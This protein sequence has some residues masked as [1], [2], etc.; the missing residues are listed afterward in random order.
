MRFGI[1]LR[2]D[3]DGWMEIYNWWVVVVVGN[4]ELTYYGNPV[5]DRFGKEGSDSYDIDEFSEENEENGNRCTMHTSSDTSQEHENVVP[6]ICIG[7]ELKERNFGGSFFL[8]RPF[9]LLFIVLVSRLSIIVT[10]PKLFSF[11][12]SSFSS[13]FLRLS[14]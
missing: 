13:L 11:L 14:L 6:G 7:E 3:W 2:P 8:F 4:K 1:W 10:I 12:H 5:W 9:H